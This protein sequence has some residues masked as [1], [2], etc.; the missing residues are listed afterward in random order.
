M[1]DLDYVSGSLRESSFLLANAGVR[2]DQLWV[3]IVILSSLRD[4]P[5][6]NI[7]GLEL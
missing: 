6:S 3:A 7:L 5:I 1:P 2:N 4:V